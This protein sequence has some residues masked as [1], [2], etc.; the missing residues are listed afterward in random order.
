MK[1]EV[2][3]ILPLL[4]E[5]YMR[6]GR[7]QKDRSERNEVRLAD[8]LDRIAPA[9]QI[10]VHEIQ[11]PKRGYFQ[12][13]LNSG[14]PISDRII[15]LD[16][17][18]GAM[19][20]EFST[21]RRYSHQE[22][23]ILK[24]ALERCRVTRD[25]LLKDTGIELDNHVVCRGLPVSPG[26]A[27]GPVFHWSEQIP[28]ESIPIGCILV[29][30][31]TRPEIV[32]YIQ[33][34]EGIVTDIGGRLCHAAIIAIEKKIPCVVGSGDAT[35]LLKSEELISVDGYDGDIRRLS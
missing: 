17:A 29:S 9:L 34:I 2:K 21:P 22:S 13:I 10:F 33:R 3:G 25:D 6:I 5:T 18:V 4:H 23:S 11:E 15:A 24:Q 20:I 8:C 7:F 27:S 1:S 19:H 30:K 28:C 16:T 14:L 35:K 32:N 12:V 31:M 26:I